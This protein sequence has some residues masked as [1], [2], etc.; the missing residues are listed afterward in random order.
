[1]YI[2]K[3]YFNVNNINNNNN[4]NIIYLINN[5]F[6][7]LNNLNSNIQIL[8][9]NNLLLT[10]F[11][12]QY[13]I[14][15]I[16]HTLYQNNNSN[17]ITSIQN[18]INNTDY[19]IFSLLN[20][21]KS[22]S[23]N[24]ILLNITTTS[25][26]NS[27][28]ILVFCIINPS[29]DEQNFLNNCLNNRIKIFFNKN[30]NTV[31]D[32]YGVCSSII[33]NNVYINLEYDIDFSTISSIFLWGYLVND[34]KTINTNYIYNL[35]LSSINE[36]N[37]L[38]F[39]YLEISQKT[40]NVLYNLLDNTYLYKILNSID[41][42]NNNIIL[43]SNND[44]LGII[45]DI[46]TV[47]DINFINYQKKVIIL[48]NSGLTKIICNDGPIISGDLLQINTNGCVKKQNISIYDICGT[49]INNIIT[50]TTI[51]KALESNSNITGF[52][53]IKCVLI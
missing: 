44:F 30:N 16:L 17:I 4:N 45:H 39:T 15:N 8:F 31:I 9:I 19:N 24:D 42:I 37:N 1:M 21:I 6:F 47:P 11:N 33:N 14:L 49:I 43:A 23:K 46:I 20:L 32:N 3:Y 25:F 53:T 10:S 36:I 52:N 18:T 26:Y 29:N 2:K 51:C 34:F 50:S 22:N 12:D 27:N 35:A 40:Y 7:I 28:N 41:Y 5:L 48:I 38:N 13:N